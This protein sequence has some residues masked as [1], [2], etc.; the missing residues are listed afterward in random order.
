MNYFLYPL[1]FDAPVHFGTAECG[2]GLEHTRFTLSSDA[3]FSALLAE[4]YHA[5]ETVSARTFL[6]KVQKGQLRFSDLLPWQETS[7][8]E[9]YFY[10][11]RPILPVKPADC[12]SMSYA[13]VCHMASAWKR[14]KKIGYIRASRMAA[15][16]K[17]VQEGRSFIEE[18]TFG[19]EVLRQRVNCR[20]EE[21]LPYFVDSFIFDNSSGLYVILAAE[22]EEDAAFFANVLTFVGFSGLGGKRS[23]GYGKF[24]M[25]DDRIQLD[26]YEICGADDAALYHLLQGKQSSWQMALSSVIPEESELDLVCRGAYRLRRAGGFVTDDSFAEKKNSICLIEAG[27]CFRARING[28]IISLG[29]HGGHPILRCGYGLYV[30]IAG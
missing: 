17:A 5:D 12:S 23:S 25:A 3:L 19:Q 20:E 18:N 15:Y 13:S 22:Q 7:N 14:Q 9:L 2:G 6:D 16:I 29:T 10:L 4:M 21:S 27:S 24:H 8:G 28:Q 30:G 26:D 1:R 11:P